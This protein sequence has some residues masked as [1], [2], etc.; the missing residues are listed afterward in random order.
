MERT[1]GGKIRAMILELF[2]NYIIWL[3]ITAVV[4]IWYFYPDLIQNLGQTILFYAPSIALIFGFLIALAGIHWKTKRDE[5]K[6]ITQYDIIITKGTLYLVDFL[7]YGGTILI[8]AIPF[9]LKSGVDL[10][11][12]LPAIIYFI[13]AKWLKQSFYNKMSK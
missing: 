5:E 9:I 10:A 4:F 3:I 12:L 7:I 8:L 1:T 6:G 13:L 11:D 2:S